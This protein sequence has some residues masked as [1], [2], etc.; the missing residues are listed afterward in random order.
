MFT[1]VTKMTSDMSRFVDYSDGDT[2]STVITG[3]LGE[4]VRKICGS[5]IQ[6]IFVQIFLGGFKFTRV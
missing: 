5:T 6:I 2:D 1:S 3:N 4:Y